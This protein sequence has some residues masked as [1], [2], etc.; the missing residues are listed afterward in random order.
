MRKI[1]TLL[2]YAAMVVAGLSLAGHSIIYGG[3]AIVLVAGGFLTIFGTF[4]ICT[5]FPLLVYILM[6]ISGLSLLIYS[7]LYGNAVPGL[8]AGGT[9][10]ASGALLIWTNYVRPKST[11]E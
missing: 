3:R 9:L 7:V 10:I 8:L 6:L 1:L 4:L 2:F 11:A 5:D